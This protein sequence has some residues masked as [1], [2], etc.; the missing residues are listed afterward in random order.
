MNTIVTKS[1]ITELKDAASG[2]AT[3]DNFAC[4]TLDG[5]DY[6]IHMKMLQI[7]TYDLIIKIVDSEIFL[8]IK[9]LI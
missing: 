6:F 8:L 5:E 2:E 9:N 1:A 3:F 4:L 7:C